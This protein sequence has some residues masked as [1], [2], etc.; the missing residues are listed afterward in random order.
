MAHGESDM[1]VSN[2]TGR[3]CNEK[4]SECR[5]E[6]K[7]L[8]FHFINFLQISREKQDEVIILHNGDT[9]TFYDRD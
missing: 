4:G 6:L 5:F 1:D 9:S 8:L 2:P 7:N 3:G